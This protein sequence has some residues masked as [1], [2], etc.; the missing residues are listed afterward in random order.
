LLNN[1]LVIS[2]FE[3]G[4]EWRMALIHISNQFGTSRKIDRK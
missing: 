3:L 1:L 2:R 4:S